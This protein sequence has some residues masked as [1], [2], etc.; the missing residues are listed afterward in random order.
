M[1]LL[2][3]V[4]PIIIFLYSVQTVSLKNKNKTS[5]NYR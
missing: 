3:V 4:I 2:I 5:I 1:N